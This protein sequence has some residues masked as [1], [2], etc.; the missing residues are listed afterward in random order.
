MSSVLSVAACER[1]LNHKMTDRQLHAAAVTVWATSHKT[2]LNHC[3]GGCFF[4]SLLLL[5]APRIK[6]RH[7]KSL[8]L[9][10]SLQYATSLIKRFMYL[11]WRKQMYTTTTS[12]LLHS[13]DR[14]Q[15]AISNCIMFH[16]IKK[17]FTMKTNF[18]LSK[19]T[20]LLKV[21]EDVG[22]SRPFWCPRWDEEL[23]MLHGSD[24]GVDGRVE[25]PSP[26]AVGGFC[27]KKKCIWTVIE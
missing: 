6:T 5:N 11:Q 2:Q 15:L 18:L 9:I 16:K 24:S 7:S 13:G 19:N 25:G 21:W 20:S 14:H 8:I 10:W 26:A 4:R 22:W 12:P 1:S 3:M 23:D 27:K 17:C